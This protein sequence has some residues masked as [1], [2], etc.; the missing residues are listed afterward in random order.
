[1][2]RNIEVVGLGALNIDHLYR[3]ERILEDGESVVNETLS[4]PGGFAANTIYGLARLGVATGFCGIVGDD[5]EGRILIEDFAKDGVDTTAAPSAG[6]GQERAYP[7]LKSWGSITIGSVH[8]SYS[9]FLSPAFS[10]A[11]L[12]RTSSTIPYSTACSGSR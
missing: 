10:S 9:Y 6:Q 3:V 5:A 4:S 1:M 12:W 8:K 11:G 7:P 2:T